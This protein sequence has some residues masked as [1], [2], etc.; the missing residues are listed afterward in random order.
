M[1]RLWPT[2]QVSGLLTAQVQEEPVPHPMSFC[3]A[4]AG[5]FVPALENHVAKRRWF[6]C[7]LHPMCSLD[8]FTQPDMAKNV[9][10]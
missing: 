3:K 6:L 4:H 1:P 2:H 8:D 5:L 9:P 7:T 10:L